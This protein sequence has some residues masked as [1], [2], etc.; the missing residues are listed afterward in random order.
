MSGIGYT[1][2]IYDVFV[3]ILIVALAVFLLRFIGK[4]AQRTFSHTL[5]KSVGII[6]LGNNKTMQVFVIDEKRVLLVGVGNAIEPIADIEDPELAK[7]FLLDFESKM[8]P[9]TMM[10][11]V[12]RFLVNSM[13]TWQKKQS[14]PK[15]HKDDFATV[16]SERLESVK[17]KRTRAASEFMSERVD[18]RKDDVGDEK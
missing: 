13:N 18:K 6:P 4:R 2:Y 8:M 12:G 5:I 11:P 1:T 7:R 16:L 10:R 3:L 17:E 15:T 9:S 14:Q